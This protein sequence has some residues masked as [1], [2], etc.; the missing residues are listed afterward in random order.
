MTEF[1]LTGVVSS[2]ISKVSFEE[3]VFLVFILSH[4]KDNRYY[5][6][7][8]LPQKLFA[9]YHDMKGG[10]GDIIEVEG[11][12]ASVSVIQKEKDKN[13]MIQEI[14]CIRLIPIA[15]SLR[16][17]KRGSGDHIIKTDFLSKLLALEKVGAIKNE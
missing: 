5:L 11:L 7:I 4:G 6:P 16:F 17:V 13:K 8:Y 2:S 14:T 1:R 10:V 9:Y 3:K 15:S 12:L